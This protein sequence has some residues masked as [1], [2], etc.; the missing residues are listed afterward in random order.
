LTA[1][2]VSD[3]DFHL[4]DHLIAQDARPRGRSRLMIVDR[5]AGNWREDVIGRLPAVFSSGDLLIVN[6]TR[7]FPARLTGRRDPSGGAVEC[8]LLARLA[9][10]DWDALVSPGQKLGVG[11]RAIFDDDARA[12][13][14]TLRMEVISRGERGRRVVRF[15]TEGDRDSISFGFQDSRAE[16]ESR[17]RSVAEAI[18]ALG[19]VPL[20]PYIRRADT[21]EDRER[22]QTVYARERGSVAAPTA[23]LHFDA[24]LLAAL[25]AAGIGRAGVT[26]HVGYGTFKPVKTARVEDH[27]VDP[28][29][30]DIS[31]ATAGAIRQTRETGRRVI[32]VGTTTTR[33][34]E[35]SAAA[36]AG[37]V[38]AGSG[39][40]DNFIY[41][42]H[43]F[44]A[45]DAL[46]TNFHLPQSSLLML[47]AAFAGKEL[48]LAAYND[49]V[50]RGF[51]FYS[52]GDAMVIV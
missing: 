52:Y 38:E 21:P 36:H 42:G 35:H 20:P 34:L 37:T 2:N 50:A 49:A 31:A 26:L 46:M 16:N 4:P 8:F 47:V 30:Y 32:A 12:P 41:P 39:V 22:Y 28:E 5:A 44:A 13:G 29:P 51:H 6:D 48:V 11:A 7:V 45:V 3:F 17:S 14:V 19:H 27:V 23:G 33:A 43:R 25:E 24:A 18:D 15:S 9:N 10:G 1:T 40:A